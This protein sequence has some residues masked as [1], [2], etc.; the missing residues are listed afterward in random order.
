MSVPEL[1]P[2]N[3]VLPLAIE[4]SLTPLQI[5]SVRSSEGLVLLLVSQ[6]L[7]GGFA[8]NGEIERRTLR[9]GIGKHELVCQRRLPA[10]GW[11]AMMLNEN[12]GRPPP[13]ISSRPGTPV[14]SLLIFTLSWVL[15]LFSRVPNCDRQMLHLAM[16]CAAGLTLMLRRRRCEAVRVSSR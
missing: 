2:D 8:E 14:G 6:H 1:V 11:P 4:I 16:H 9:G 12:S 3:Q 7:D 15:T 13:T 10:S 5:I